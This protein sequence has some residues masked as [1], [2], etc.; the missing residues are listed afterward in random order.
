MAG[1]FSSLLDL[2][3]P[4]RCIFCRRLLRGG[5]T[6]VCARCSSS[7]PWT[8]RG[9]GESGEFFSQCVS[10]LWYQDDVRESFLRYKFRGRDGYAGPYGRLMASCVRDNLAG[11]Y[12]LITWVPLSPERLKDR[13]Y[14]QAMLLALSTALELQDVAVETLRKNREIARQSSLDNDES[15]R[16]NVIG[17]YSVPDPELVRGQRILLVDDVVTTGS[18]LSECARVL[19]SAGASDVVCV[20]LARARRK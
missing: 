15:R 13:G 1:F 10:P 16:A 9:A 14:D 5:E 18:T 4:P 8:E 3:F 2:L 11:K 12:D 20:T 6:D 17:V 19:R 7:L